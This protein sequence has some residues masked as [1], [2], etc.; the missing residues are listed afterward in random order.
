[1]GSS[2]SGVRNVDTLFFMLGW[3]ECGSYKKRAGSR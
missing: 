2:E 1:V 3:A